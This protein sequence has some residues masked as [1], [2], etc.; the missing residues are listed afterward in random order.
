MTAFIGMS[1]EKGNVA[2][3]TIE[4]QGTSLALACEDVMAAVQGG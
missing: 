1:P 2:A 3:E 4:G